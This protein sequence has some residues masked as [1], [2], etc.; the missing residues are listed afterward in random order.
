MPLNL[1]LRSFPLGA[2]GALGAYSISIFTPT[3]I[4]RVNSPT[5]IPTVTPELGP[6]HNYLVTVDHHATKFGSL[7]ANRFGSD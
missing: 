1:T 6:A 3:A 5:I 2:Y 7:Y 4:A